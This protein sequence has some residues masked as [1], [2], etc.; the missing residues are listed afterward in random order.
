M[1]GASLSATW[2]AATQ[3][4]MPQHRDQLIIQQAGLG[5][6][7][8]GVRRKSRRRKADARRASAQISPSRSLMRA[9]LGPT[10]CWRCTRS[11]HGA[12]QVIGREDGSEKS[13]IR[14]TLNRCCNV[15]IPLSARVWSA[16]YVFGPI[17][18]SA[19]AKQQLCP[20]R[21]LH[22]GANLPLVRLR[23]PQ[24]ASAGAAARSSANSNAPMATRQWQRG[25][26]SDPGTGRDFDNS[27]TKPSWRSSVNRSLA[28]VS[29][30][31]G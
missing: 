11:A 27:S 31:N 8:H 24:A 22:K 30:A 20:K 29:C 3:R 26:A 5:N 15:E 25:Y 2:I 6:K 12:L 1:V 7:T 16:Q 28:I 14:A 17:V 19:K 23:P 10:S 13:I 18:R 9:H 21:K 4:F